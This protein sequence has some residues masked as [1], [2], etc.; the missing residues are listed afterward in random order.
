[1]ALFRALVAVAVLAAVADAKA[2][3]SL[4][5][6]LAPLYS[7]CGG[8][9]ASCTTLP[10][11]NDSAAVT[12]EPLSTCTRLNAWYWQCLATPTVSA[13]DVD[14]VIIAPIRDEYRGIVAMLDSLKGNLTSY[15]RI[16]TVGTIAKKTVA[17]TVCGTGMNNAAMTTQMAIDLFP[18]IEYL[19]MQGIAGSLDSQYR[20]GDVV[21]AKAWAN[22]NH[23]RFIR[24]LVN[25]EGKDTNKFIDNSQPGFPNKYY[26]IDGAYKGFALPYST[27]PLP[28][29][30]EEE[31]KAAEAAGF[32]VYD[33]FQVPMDI[34]V[35]T[36]PLDGI[37][38]DE[39][40]MPQQ[41]WLNV[42]ST[43]YNL[44]MEVTKELTLL[45]GTMGE[46]G[47]FNSL[48]YQPE[49]KF[50]TNGLAASVFM[51]NAAYRDELSSSYQAGLLEMEGAA[52]M[53]VCLSCKAECIVIRTVSDLAGGEAALNEVLTFL[54]IASKNTAMVTHALVA[55]L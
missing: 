28:T 2:A 5:S 25:K 40:G 6:G 46:D 55:A 36:D 8:K 51:D 44:T 18:N 16:F 22:F 20:I 42:S 41:F 29:A 50:G 11:C 21:I 13:K 17:V 14:I 43:L 10:S 26:Q 48:G 35:M 3:R 34:E 33:G 30:T 54:S 32:I 45:N 27:K 49:V 52:F 19:I 53:H 47:T 31:I 15:G 39:P 9:G 38:Y 24:S 37:T 7:Q 1:M 12:C 4:I 23:A